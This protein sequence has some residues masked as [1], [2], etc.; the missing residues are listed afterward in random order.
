MS[1]E[2][3][4][5]LSCPAVRGQQKGKGEAT[6]SKMAFPACPCIFPSGRWTLEV[7]SSDRL[8]SK[9]GYPLNSSQLNW[10]ARYPST[11]R[12]AEARLG[13]QDTWT[14]THRNGRARSCRGS[15]ASPSPLSGLSSLSKLL[16]LVATEDTSALEG[17][18]SVPLFNCFTVLTKPLGGLGVGTARSAAREVTPRRKILKSCIP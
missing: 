14:Y 11:V 1:V 16:L 2:S 15:S 7:S 4:F 10:A 8:Q 3:R 17:I 18:C 5:K 9:G 6:P 12:V 13:S